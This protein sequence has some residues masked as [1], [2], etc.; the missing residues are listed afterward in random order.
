MI[1]VLGSRL[2]VSVSIVLASSILKTVSWDSATSAV[3]A[4]ACTARSG[5]SYLR[6]A[7]SACGW[8]YDNGLRFCSHSHICS[9]SAWSLPR[10]E[11]AA[12]RSKNNLPILLPHFYILWISC[13]FDTKPLRT[14]SYLCSHTLA[15]LEQA[16]IFTTTPL[17]TGSKQL[18]FVLAAQNGF[19]FQCHLTGITCRH[20]H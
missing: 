17:S 2:A 10:L 8:S 9:L 19:C 5:L 15:S 6:I 20:N 1:Q 16:A 13:L 11:V 4:C 3:E 7:I 14:S 18:F 12:S